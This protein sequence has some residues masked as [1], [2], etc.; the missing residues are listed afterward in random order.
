MTVFEYLSVLTSVIVG[1]G[2]THVLAGM[3][4]RDALIAKTT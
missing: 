4:L 2:V 3:G 1:L